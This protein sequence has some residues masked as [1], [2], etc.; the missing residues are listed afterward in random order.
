LIGNI[1]QIVAANNFLYVFGIDSINVISDVRISPTTGSTL[2][3][4]TNISAA[5]GTDLPY[6]LL[7]YFR[8]IVFMNRYGVYALVG[9]TTS[10]LSDALDGVFPYIDFTK[11]ISAGQVLIYNILCAAF[12]FTYNDP[13]TST[14]RVIQAVYFDKK[15]FFTSQGTLTFIAQAPIN[16]AATLYGTTGTDLIK[17][18]QDKTSAISSTIRSALLGMKDIIRDKQALKWGV[19]AILGD[20][21]GSGLTITV[22]NENR[23]SPSTTVYNYNVVTWT[24][25]SGTTIPWTNSAGTIIGWVDAVVG[26][27]LYRYDAQQWGKYIG[28]TI[29]S[30][31][32][33]FIISGVQY[34][35]TLRARF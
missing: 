5:V 22:D 17:L 16:G 4:N 20:T 10:K 13:L 35:T 18:Y 6:G 8:S 30:T 25:S 29:T 3:T 24:N 32:P 14:A 2:Y 31:S 23:S 21:I 1:T 9:S 33:N 27:Y 12:S 19:E 34:E 28:L 26:Y 11:T 7:P 15:W